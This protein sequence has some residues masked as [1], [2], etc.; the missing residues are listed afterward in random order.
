MNKDFKPPIRLWVRKYKSNVFI[1]L[2]IM[3]VTI[4]IL[5]ET[6]L[7]DRTYFF[8]T[9]INFIILAVF[10]LGWIVVYYVKPTWFKH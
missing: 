8:R 1:S 7:R 10:G 2:I 9:G 3:L 4:L 6:I 5:D